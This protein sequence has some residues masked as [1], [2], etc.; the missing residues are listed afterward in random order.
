MNYIEF[1]H[2]RDKY[3]GENHDDFLMHYGVLGQKWGQRHWQNPDGTYTTEGKIRYFG[4]KKA[5]AEIN[6]DETKVG[7]K[8]SDVKDYLKFR[9]KMLKERTRSDLNE[10]YRD[11]NKYLDKQ[12]V[13]D[14]KRVDKQ[15]EKMYKNQLKEWYDNPEDLVSDLNAMY[16]IGGKAGKKDKNWEKIYEANKDNPEMLKILKDFYKNNENDVAP[17]PDMAEYEAEKDAKLLKDQKVGS[18]LSDADNAI[19]AYNTVQNKMKNDSINEIAKKFAKGKTDDVAIIIDD[20]ERIAKKMI[21]A[22]EKGNMKKYMKLRNKI[23]DDFEKDIIEEYVN[24]M[25]DKEENHL[26]EYYIDSAFGD[27]Q[28]IGGLFSKKEKESVED[29]E[30][31]LNREFIEYQDKVNKKYDEIKG[32]KKADNDATGGIDD[33]NHY[34]DDSDYSSEELKDNKKRVEEFKKNYDKHLNIILDEIVE[35]ET[36]NGVVPTWYNGED[37]SPEQFKRCLYTNLNWQG[38]SLNGAGVGD[39]GKESLEVWVNDDGLFGYHSFVLNYDPLTKKVTDYEG[40]M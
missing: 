17:D 26:A 31:R 2:N 11:K 39:P 29:M 34:Y 15:Q 23:D 18:W 7:S 28:K 35:R 36:E 13:R 16:K 25:R 1:L 20:N 32:T 21:E 14:A 9:N 40:M 37:I 3:L 33:K 24:K 27:D 5:Q 10:W 22:L 8:K 12:L 6:A 4:S 19:A 30:A 38:K